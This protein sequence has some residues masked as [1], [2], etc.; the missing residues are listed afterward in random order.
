MLEKLFFIGL[1]HAIESP[2]FISGQRSVFEKMCE[3]KTSK[4]STK[5]R[6]SGLSYVDGI[7][8]YQVE[9]KG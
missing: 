9:L 6:N 2:S 1:C 8:E 3:K 4:T 7:Y 5:V